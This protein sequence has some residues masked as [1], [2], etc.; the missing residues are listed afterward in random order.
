MLDGDQCRFTYR[1]SRFKHDNRWVVLGVR[2]RLGRS[3]ESTPV[4][5]ANAHSAGDITSTRPVSRSNTRTDSTL[6]DTSWP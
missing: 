1:S 3:A 2:F 6:S 4:R 5:Y